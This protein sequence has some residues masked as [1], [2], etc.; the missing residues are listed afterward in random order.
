[1]MEA[2]AEEIKI[3]N[4]TPSYYRY[5]HNILITKKNRRLKELCDYNDIIELHTLYRV[6]YDINIPK[7]LVYTVIK[8]MEYY[9]LLEI[10]NQRTIKIKKAA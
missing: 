1:M 2:L 4:I 3:N 6:L 10:V 5:I 8:E 7:N 9:Q